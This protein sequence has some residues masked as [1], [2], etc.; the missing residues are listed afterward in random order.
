MQSAANADVL[1]RSGQ[2]LCSVA[3][4]KT[5]PLL[6]DSQVTNVLH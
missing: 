1:E 5:A 6:R 4:G 3:S 2:L